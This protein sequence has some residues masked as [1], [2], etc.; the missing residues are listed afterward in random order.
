MKNYSLT[1]L[2]LLCTLNSSAQK[3][4]IEIGAAGYTF[5]QITEQQKD[6]INVASL[7][8][9]RHIHK[10]WFA[11][12]QYNK[13]PIKGWLLVQERPGLAKESVQ[14]LTSRNKYNYFDLGMR[15]QVY[16]VKQH[17]LSISG[18]LSFAYGTNSYLLNVIWTEPEPGEPYGHPI[19]A[20]VQTKKEGYIG[21]LLGFRYDYRLWKNR[22][23]LGA[24]ITA[25]AYTRDFPFQINYGI[26][27]GYNF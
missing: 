18:G 13:L 15:Y 2:I 8:Y 24:G 22:I 19:D 26:H 12:L 27:A 17:H 16:Q 21:G 11:F 23:N 20:Q 14:K 25:R 4:G 9:N 1:F 5:Y 10:K 7:G 6:L 3:N